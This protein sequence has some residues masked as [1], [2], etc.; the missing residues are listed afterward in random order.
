MN[1]R[2]LQLPWRALVLAC[3][4]L[5]V[6]RAAAA[7]TPKEMMDRGQWRAVKAQ[8][9]TRVKANANDAEGQW[10]LSR[11][12]EAFGDR[13]GAFAA[14]DKAV[15]LEPKN[16][17]YQAQLADAAG[18]I[19]QHA[20]PL[21]QLSMAKKMKKA[22][23]TALELDPKQWD[24]RESL[25]EFY[26]QAPGMMGGDKSK[27][28]GLVTDAEKLD[29]VQGHL[30]AARLARDQKDTVAVEREIRAAAAAGPN[31]YE[32]RVAMAN[33]LA[34][35][36]QWAQ[37]ETEAK[38]AR[39]LDPKRPSCDLLLT[40][41]YAAQHRTDDVEATIADYEK[42]FPGNRGAE[43]QA[44]R[45]YLTDNYDLPRA[46]KWLRAYVAVEPEG[47]QPDLAHAHWRLGQVLAAQNKKTEAKAEFETAHQL[48][49][50][51]KEVKEDLKKL[52]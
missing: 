20:G 22:C 51:M 31:D 21:K 14:A 44:A 18:S 49:P 42:T 7:D 5:T 19:A 23:E 43:Y 9:E 2:T 38:A 4:T 28:A 34:G 39:D 10:M 41:I 33:W 17:A 32:A 8:A 6:A 16:A 29:A 26:L 25:M 3:A 27:A 50:Q 13:D 52:G 40:I 12:C 1:P 37:A 35:H 11:A 45:V 48:D 36:R 47:G 24:A 30:L 46:E 15:T